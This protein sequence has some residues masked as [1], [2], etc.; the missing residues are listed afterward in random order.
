M[1]IEV[2]MPFS[3]VDIVSHLDYGT[4]EK[5]LFKGAIFINENKEVV[6]TVVECNNVIAAAKKDEIVEQVQIPTVKILESNMAETRD[7]TAYEL[8][9]F[10]RNQNLFLLRTPMAI[11]TERLFLLRLNFNVNVGDVIELINGNKIAINEKVLVSIGIPNVLTDGFLI[12]VETQN[13][14]ENTEIVGPYA[15]SLDD[16]LKNIAEHVV[17]VYPQQEATDNDDSGELR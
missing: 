10:I 6:F 17:F 13:G 2:K 16:F 8:L 1:N 11:Y 12:S 4:F 5:F 9:N 3:F 14:E 15:I 7:V